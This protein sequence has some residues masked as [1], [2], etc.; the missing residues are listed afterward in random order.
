[1]KKIRKTVGIILAVLLF[2]NMSLSLA[3][4]FEAKTENF[5]ENSEDYVLDNDINFASPS[6]AYEDEEY[7]PDNVVPATAS[8]YVYEDFSKYYTKPDYGDEDTPRRRSKR[9][10]VYEEEK[11]LSDYVK[12]YKKAKKLEGLTNVWEVS[13]GV[14]AKDIQE[15]SDIVLVI[16]RSGSMNNNGRMDKA[17]RAGNKF[18]DTIFD[19]T[20][21]KSYSRT[22]VAVISYSSDV[23]LDSALVGYAGRQTLKSKINSMTAG[24]GTFTQAGLKHAR[25]LL[26]NSTAKHKSIILLSDGEPTYSYGLKQPDDFVEHYKTENWLWYTYTHYKTSTAPKE[27]DYNYATSDRVGNGTRL[28]TEYR[29]TTRGS[30]VTVYEYDHG[31]SAIAEASIVKSSGISIYAIGLQTVDEGSRVL[32]EIGAGSGGFTEVQDVNELERVFEN[33]ANNILLSMKNI[34]ISDPMGQGIVIPNGYLSDITVTQGTYTYDSNTRTLNWDVG[35]ELINYKA[36]QNGV[37]YAEIKYKVTLDDGIAGTQSADGQYFTNGN[38]TVKYQDQG[39]GEKKGEFPKPKV[40]PIVVVLEKKLIDSKGKV[41][42]QSDPANRN[43]K[44]RLTGRKGGAIVYQKDY[45]LKAGQKKIADD[46]KVDANYTVEE[47]FDNAAGVN[48]EDYLLNISLKNKTATSYTQTN[49][50][51]LGNENSDY[52]ILISNTEKKLGKIKV[53]KNFVSSPDGGKTV[54]EGDENLASNPEYS[55]ELKS[56]DGSYRQNFKLKAGEEKVFENLSYGDYT[57][58]ELNVPSN[59]RVSYADDDISTSKTDGKVSLTIGEKE[60][61]FTVTNTP[62]DISTELKVK[63]EWLNTAPANSELNFKLLGDGKELKRIKNGVEEKITFKLGNAN[64]W[65]TKITELPKYDSKGKLIKY[66]VEEQAVPS[67]YSVEYDDKIAGTITV[68]NRKNTS[69]RLIK[70]VAGN[71]GDKNKKFKFKVSVQRNNKE[72]YTENTEL[73]N[74]EIFFIDSF[75][76]K[77]DG[78]QDYIRAG[79]EIRVAEL[80]AVDDG[81]TV[82]ADLGNLSISGNIATVKYSVKTSDSDIS[83]NINNTKN[84]I[85]QT[86][87]N[88]QK[89]NKFPYIFTIVTCCLF[90]VIFTCMP[91]KDRRS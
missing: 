48:G 72:I 39:G 9:S 49:T 13:L 47:I 85:P 28:T 50:F 79:D 15:D 68:K 3:L 64:S 53:V 5:E 34:S 66:T 77:L 20:K 60:K 65:Q 35:K 58:K 8:D 32:R 26:K 51:Y 1:M 24:G 57:L 43:F 17:R 90:M 88:L 89:N 74:T 40:N 16:D 10:P 33:A 69:F 44:I 67:G 84:L 46:L 36:G 37:R 56:T 81:Y 41:I 63:K 82:N 76:N 45:I 61:K 38:A 12:L 21:N 87:I 59:I 71:A 91:K 11:K 2:L 80:N 55:F 31:N 6:N 19:T 52:D 27:R 86:G 23:R 75:E 4:G 70:N 22:R 62:T 73:K 18:I 7:N 30:K 14:E 78:Q 25:D 54:L 42:T 83:M 29:R